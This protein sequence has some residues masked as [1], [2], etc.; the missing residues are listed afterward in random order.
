MAPYQNTRSGLHSSQQVQE[1]PPNEDTSS[2][3]SFT[4]QVGDEQPLQNTR[5][6]SSPQV[7]DKQPYQS[8]PSLQARD[9]RPCYLLNIHPEIRNEIYRLV[10]VSNG[11][12]EVA[13]ADTPPMDPPLLRTCSQIRTEARGIFYKE[14]KVRFTVK[15]YDIRKIVAW[16]DRSAARHDLLANAHLALSVS[17]D[18]VFCW[19]ALLNWA[20]AYREGRCGRLTLDASSIAPNDVHTKDADRLEA[21]AMFDAVE[22]NSAARRFKFDANFLRDT[23]LTYHGNHMNGGIWWDHPS[24]PPPS[25]LYLHFL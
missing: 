17:S 20:Y 6:K 24:F 7:E 16:L 4:S 12:I 2:D 21:I 18:W 11:V 1:E 9:E 10:L 8:K 22:N 15:N 19:Y 14:N 25:D 3:S 13:S 23:L 5:A